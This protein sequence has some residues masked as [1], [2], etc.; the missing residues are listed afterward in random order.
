M[1]INKNT[2]RSNKKRKLNLLL[3]LFYFFLFNTI[4][5]SQSSTATESI[6]GNLV[7]VEW[8]E[9]NLKSPQVLI[10]DAS[11]PPQYAS[12]HI[13]GAILVDFMSYGVKESSTAEIEERYQSWGISTDKKIVIYDRGTPMMATRVFFDL[14]YNGFPAA[15]LFIL[16]GGFTKWQ[17]SGKLVSNESSAALKKSSFKINKFSEEIRA[18]LPEFLTASG[19]Q[20]NNILI[21]ALDA[22]WHFGEFQ[23]FDRPGHIPYG[24]ML[25]S[26][27]FFNPDKTFK[28]PE[29][30]K[31]ILDYLGITSQKKIY[32]YCGGGIAATVPFFALKF[33][34][35]FPDVKLF[36]ESEMGWMLDERELPV[37]T[38]DAPYLMRETDWLKTWGG[39]MM[40]MYG[41]SKVNIIDVSSVEEY[42]QGH[43]PFAS[44]IPSEL[45]KKNIKDPEKL[46]EL[47]G[48]AGVNPSYEAVIV[49]GEGLNE[50]SALAFLILEYLGQKKIS[51]FIDSNE[52]FAQRGIP[53]EK[54]ENGTDPK[55]G[56]ENT[57]APA[58][59]Y[60]LKIQNEILNTDLNSTSGLYPKVFI[61][62]G[63]TVSSKIHG[64]KI[65]HVPYSDLLTAEGTPKTAKEIWNIIDNAGVPRYAEL[66]CISD[67]P[68]ESAV[69]YFIF[70]LM[71]F[72]DIKVIVL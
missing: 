28:S 25:P 67:D 46:A 10:L 47:L 69:N 42:N 53:L 34:L 48:Q 11:Q 58:P 3:S 35:N 7:S 2:T 29:E 20:K 63:R 68:G 56:K 40:R 18:K 22:N 13:P 44:N 38:Y 36:R 65:V 12:Q 49:S 50:H 60:P 70:K 54:E 43:I 30:T 55:N 24:I 5:L 64:G 45:L 41:V 61:A 71:G 9:K 21:E 1:I 6:K 72:P 57:S 16:N 27:D 4:L 31:K 51:I 59:V 39:K 15:N 23:F 26:A 32:T 14:Y 19:D 62:S 66:I 33:I 37:W 52:K 17:E 8:L